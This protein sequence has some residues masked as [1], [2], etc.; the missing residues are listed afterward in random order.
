MQYR[1]GRLLKTTANVTDELPDRHSYVCTA[2]LNVTVQSQRGRTDSRVNA[3]TSP[4]GWW[5][6]LPV[7]AVVGV[8]YWNRPLASDSILTITHL[9][10]LLVNSPYRAVNTFSIG[11]ENI[12]VNAVHW[13]N[14]ILFW[15]QYKTHKTHKCTVWASRKISACKVVVHIVTTGL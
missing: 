14:R 4:A 1:S 5:C 2:L 6:V 9:L 10:R 15:D 3:A 12:S 13:N 8:K 7:T 11:Y